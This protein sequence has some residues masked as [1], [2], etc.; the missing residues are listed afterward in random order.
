MFVRT[1]VLLGV[2]HTNA[3]ILKEWARNP[4]PDCR[5]VCISRFLTA[6]YSGMLPGTLAGQFSPDEMQIDLQK[7]VARAGATLILADVTSVD[8]SRRVLHFDNAESLKFDILSIGVGSR[9][10]GL[11]E[12]NAACLVPIKPMQTFL[13]RL[14]E[15]LDIVAPKPG[16]LLKIAIVGGGVASIEIALCLQ[17]RLHFDFP[18]ANIRIRI[19]TSADEIVDELPTPSIKR[20]RLILQARGIQVVTQSRVTDADDSS[21]T[22]NGVDRQ[23]ADCVIWSTGAAAP[24]VLSRLGLPEDS[25]GFLATKPTLQ[26]TVDPLVFAV[27]DSGS[28][29]ETPF[30]K[31]GV[32]AVRQS[33]I[34]WH[35][36]KALLNGGPLLEFKPQSDFLKLLNTGDGRALL[37]YK[38]LT[39]HARW[40]WILKTWIDRK[41][42]KNFQIQN[43]RIIER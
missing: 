33:P 12:E 2:G 32:Y 14:D 15:R 35:N 29:P 18:Q 42:L 19:L 13:Q 43:G 24:P 41:F 28:I 7:L 5:L 8:W 21:I 17:R 4:V 27:G 26:S 40:C 36:I 9:P 20:V 10:A 38:S 34:L 3:H 39:V 37:L 1:V 16:Q 25:R 11:L 22:I 23:S 6:T 30:P 31:A